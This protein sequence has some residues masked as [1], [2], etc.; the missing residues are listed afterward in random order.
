MGT[1]ADAAKALEDEVIRQAEQLNHLD[2]RV[3]ALEAGG[4]PV[5]PEPVPPEITW[6]NVSAGTKFN[7]GGV[8]VA[9]EAPPRNDAFQKGSDGKSAH[10]TVRTGETADVGRGRCEF[11]TTEYNEHG[12]HVEFTVVVGQSEG[13]GNDNYN[14]TSQYHP[15]NDTE[16]PSASINYQMNKFT[17]QTSEGTGSSIKSHGSLPVNAGDEVKVMWDVTFGTNGTL[18]C[19]MYNVTT[20]EH[21]LVEYNGPMG[22]AGRL[23]NFKAGTYRQTAR[24]NY[25]CTYTDIVIQDVPAVA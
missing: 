23:H 13:S 6:T 20:D 15:N 10:M 8:Q 11:R 7:L 1:F 5:P 3:T 21:E 14:V 16:N 24:S 25:E 22:K 19:E 18:R 9:V 2:T 4:T 12:K 17:V